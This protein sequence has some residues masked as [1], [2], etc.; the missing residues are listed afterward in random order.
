MKTKIIVA[1]L[2]MLNF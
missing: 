2:T 1:S